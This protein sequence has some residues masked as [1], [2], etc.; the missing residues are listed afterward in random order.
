MSST[1]VHHVLYMYAVNLQKE[2]I[3]IGVTWALEKLIPLL[4]LGDQWVVYLL[5]S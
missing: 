2:R 4:L 5:S 1:F 3:E